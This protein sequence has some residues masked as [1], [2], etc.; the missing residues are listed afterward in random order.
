MLINTIRHYWETFVDIY[1]LKRSLL[2]DGMIQHLKVSIHCHKNITIHR[3]IAIVTRLAEC[4]VQGSTLAV[5]WHL[6]LVSHDQI[7]FMSVLTT[8]KLQ[9]DH[10]RL[11]FYAIHNHVYTTMHTNNIEHK[12]YWYTEVYIN[13]CIGLSC[14][15]IHQ[16]IDIS[17]H[18]Y[19]HCNNFFG[20]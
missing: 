16:C 3:Y 5:N 9:S 1:F 20:I 2:R 19:G 13:T 11:I 18:L 10:T 4:V 7:I 8:T 14:I 6:C 17:S 12:M 15:A